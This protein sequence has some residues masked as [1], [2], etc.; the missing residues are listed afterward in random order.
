MAKRKIKEKA[1]NIGKKMF[2]IAKGLAPVVAFVDQI[3]AKDRQTLGSQFST[4]P[5]IEKLKMLSNIITGRLT[6]ISLFNN[7]VAP[8]QTIN[9]SGI[10]NKWTNAG[11]IMLLYKVLGSQINKVSGMSIAPATSKIGSIGKGLIVGGG[12]GG[13]FDDAPTNPNGTSKFYVTNYNPN[14]IQITTNG[15]SYSGSDS[16]ESSFN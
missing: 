3:S 13:F 5:T 16:T 7:G 14:P 15:S 6:G 4:A 12:I 8:P 9:P 1:F 10:L 11:G 2:P